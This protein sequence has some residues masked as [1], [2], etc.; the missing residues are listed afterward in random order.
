M[1]K[2]ENCGN[3]Y[4]KTFK[5]IMFNVEHEFDCFEC[6]INKLAPICNA[7]GTK[8]IGHGLENA[9]DTYCCASCARVMGETSLKD[10]SGEALDEIM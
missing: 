10:H 4:E 3:A 5:V 6:A 8:I 1:G 9:L 2:C 7:C